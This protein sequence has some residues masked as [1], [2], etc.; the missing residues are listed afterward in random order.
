VPC[1]ASLEELDRAAAGFAVTDLGL[2]MEAPALAAARRSLEESGYLLLGEVHGVRENPLVIHS[3]MQAFGLTGLALESHEDLAPVTGAFMTGGQL[4]ESPLLWFGDGRITAGHLAVLRERAAAG[5]LTLTLFDATIGAGW[6]WSEH[7]EAM[8]SRILAASAPATGTLVV[9]GNA[10]TPITCTDLGM[11]LG[12]HLARQRPGL[13]EIRISYRGGHYYNIEPRQFRH[14]AAPR[15]RQVRLYQQRGSL[16]L[17]L[18]A[19]TEAVV[20]QRPL[21]WPAGRTWDESHSSR[22]EVHERAT[23]ER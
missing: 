18:P 21:P 19:A 12:A 3:L 7:D 4:A 22:S 5:P 15:R 16:V 13:R 17:D 11:P 9:A 23:D 20:P 2:A 1:V 10:H 8:A 14:R 6:S